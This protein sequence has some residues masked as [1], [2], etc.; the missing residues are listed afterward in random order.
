M[1]TSTLRAVGGSVMMAIPKTL[2]DGLGLEANEKVQLSIEG[3][4]LI[5]EPRPQ[6]KYKLADLLAECD[7]SAAPHKDKD[8]DEAPPVGREVL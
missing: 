2:L 8:W 5:V 6:P 3:N 1:I 4:R 7:P